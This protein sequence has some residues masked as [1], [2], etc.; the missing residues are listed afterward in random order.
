MGKKS[1]FLIFIFLFS[2]NFIVAEAIS[3]RQDAQLNEP[4]IISQ[5]CASCSYINI[6][7]F[8]ENGVVLD[9]VPMTN[10][11]STWTYTFTPNTSVRHDVNGIGDINGIDDS[12]AFYFY[13]EPINVS[14]TIFM[15]II[16]A[17]VIIGLATIHHRTDFEKWY[18]NVLNKDD[19][20]VKSVFAA[21]KYSFMKDIYLV[22]YLLGFPMIFLITDLI[23]YFNLSSI[24]Y[25]FEVFSRI[26][27]V[28]LVVPG[29]IILSNIIKT[30]REMAEDLTNKNWG[31]E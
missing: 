17:G 7:V 27:T 22:Y 23:T 15:L 11:G 30:V 5:P 25:I 6:S 13:V 18:T 21:I 3:Q 29:I 20:G 26:Y 28:G 10:N 24:A 12:F 8:N 16:L 19:L 2:L 31:I 9:N 14:A 4:Y 1:I